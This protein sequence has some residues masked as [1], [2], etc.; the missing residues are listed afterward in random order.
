MCSEENALHQG[1]E[2][3]AQD[4]ERFKMSGV[5]MSAIKH[6]NISKTGNL[7]ASG[8]DHDM[9]HSPMS[10]HSPPGLLFFQQFLISLDCT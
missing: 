7:S 2:R 4:G 3:L 10:Y 8:T 1:D 6:C 5:S 9:S